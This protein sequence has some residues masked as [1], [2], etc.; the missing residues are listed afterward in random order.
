MKK[1]VIAAV[2]ALFMVAAG[3]AFAGAPQGKS[4]GS[5]GFPDKDRLNLTTDQQKKLVDLQEK[6]F[7]DNEKITDEM[8]KQRFALKRLYLADKPDIKAIDKLQDEIRSIGDK[9]VAIM[10][11]FR[12]KARA[13]LT[14]EQLAADPYAFMGPGFGMRGAGLGPDW[15]AKDRHHDHHWFSFHKWWKG[16]RN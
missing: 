11:E 7:T 2:A 4:P 14:D 13:L 6:L 3:L 8:M 9:R 5:V 15:R 10:R 12:D 16:H 1:Y